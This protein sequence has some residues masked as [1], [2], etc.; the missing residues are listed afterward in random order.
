MVALSIILTCPV[1]IRKYINIP[2]TQ[3]LPK[4]ATY[5]YFIGVNIACNAS[6]RKVMNKNHKTMTTSNVT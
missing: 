5:R 2:E 3:P 1:I 6:Q 4:V